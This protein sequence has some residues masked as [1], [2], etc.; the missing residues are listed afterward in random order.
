MS[1]KKKKRESSAKEK[2]KRKRLP[3]LALSNVVH[4]GGCTGVTHI[5]RKNS[6]VAEFSFLSINRLWKNQSM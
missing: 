1:R 2:R 3:F 4:L 6:L 5:Y